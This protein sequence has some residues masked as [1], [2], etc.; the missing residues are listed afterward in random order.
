MVK[1]WLKN[2]VRSLHDVWKCR[3]SLLTKIKNHVDA[4]ST[5]WSPHCLERLHALEAQRQSVQPVG[6]TL[7]QSSYASARIERVRRHTIERQ[8]QVWTK[9][10]CPACLSKVNRPADKARLVC[11]SC[12]GRYDIR[13]EVPVMS[14]KD[15]NWAKKQDEIEGEVVFNARTVPFHVHEQRNL[16]V[17]LHRRDL[18]QAADVNLSQDEILLAGCSGSEAECFEPPARST[19]ALN[20]VP[21]RTVSGRRHCVDQG[22]DVAWICGDGEALP[23]PSESFDTVIV[24][25]SLHHMLKCYSA[26]SE[27]FRVCRVGGR[28]ILIEEP[29]SQA[30]L[31]DAVFAGL[32][33]DYRIYD[34]ICLGDLRRHLGLTGSAG[35]CKQKKESDP[36]G[37]LLPGQRRCGR[38]LANKRVGF[39][40]I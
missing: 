11:V 8:A 20:I 25:Q 2:P 17:N 31:T 23:F 18:L 27:F 22:W 1:A 32:P 28:I 3:A 5:R 26:I 12:G 21:E 37:L 16:F 24:R 39:R 14:V 35:T 33:D 13:E 9:L 34:S 38:S 15:P 29:Y 30:D 19:F 4:F 40:G 7:H 6:T 10:V 36:I